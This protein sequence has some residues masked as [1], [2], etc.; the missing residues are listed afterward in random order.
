MWLTE[1]PLANVFRRREN[2]GDPVNDRRLR[3]QVD[4]GFVV[5]IA[6]G[7][8]VERLAWESLTPLARHA[9]RVW[10]AT[11]RMSDGQVVSHLAA[12]ALHGIDIL[13]EWP[14]T[15]DVSIAA[16]SGGRSTGV[17][18]RHTRDLGSVSTMP[19]GRHRVTTPLQ[20]T[21]D[22]IACRRFVEAVAIADQ[23]L[24][25]RRA[26]GALVEHDELRDAAHSRTGRGAARAVRA[27]EFATSLADSIRESQSRVLISTLGFPTP[28][29]QARFVLSSGRAAYSDF[30][31]REH[32][33]IGEFDGAGKYLD[34]AFLRGRTPEQALLEEKDREDELR[35]RVHAFSRW[36]VPALNAPRLLYDILHS[37]GLP[38]SRPRPGR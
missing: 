25:G 10:E 23:A 35:R 4:T 9:Q 33:H 22:L 11:A 30:F 27:A 31:W 14:S 5:R 37:A 24:W 21:L 19:W 13:G 12:A 6:R 36:R 26:R 7:A 20:T 34:P 29:L 28:E 18:R 38:T 8:F 1:P 17:I 15:V 2:D 32:S 16:A 3:A